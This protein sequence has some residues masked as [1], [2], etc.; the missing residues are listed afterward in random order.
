MRDCRPVLSSMWQNHD[1]RQTGTRLCTASG[2][3]ATPTSTRLTTA[4][5]VQPLESSS[6]LTHPFPRACFWSNKTARWSQRATVRGSV[7]TPCGMT[8]FGQCHR[9][10]PSA[11]PERLHNRRPTR[12]EVKTPASRHVL[13]PAPDSV[14][15][16]K[17]SVRGCPTTNIK[18][19][20][21]AWSGIRDQGRSHRVHS[22]HQ[23]IHSI[24]GARW[25]RL[26][27]IARLFRLVVPCQEPRPDWDP[28]APVGPFNCR[29]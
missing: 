28:V 14:T 29:F 20:V 24:A 13:K 1:S 23:A 19:L 17:W 25:P 4:K 10:R 16:R 12:P 6:A 5:R 27:G 8:G 21:D 7:P 2:A 11:T 9:A 18:I 3:K 15:G 22:N 26:V